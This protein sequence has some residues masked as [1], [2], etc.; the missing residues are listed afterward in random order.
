VQHPNDPHVIEAGTDITSLHEATIWERSG[1]RLALLL[2]ELRPDKVYSD[3]H[4]A[5]RLHVT[6]GVNPRM[7]QQ[8][9]AAAMPE[10][11]EAPME[12]NRESVKTLEIEPTK[13]LEAESA[14]PLE[15]Q[16]T[17]TETPFLFTEESQNP[18]MTAATLR[19]ALTKGK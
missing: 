14:N 2:V 3:V 8:E 10:S 11:D 12:E 6:N 1:R 5:F 19:K 7:L 13:T 9:H 17:A 15:G 18:K 16:V 4:N